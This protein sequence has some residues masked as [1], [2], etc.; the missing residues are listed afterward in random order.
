M[1][2]TGKLNLK[3]FIYRRKL[4]RS[5]HLGGSLREPC[6]SAPEPLRT[7][8]PETFP[9]R[10]R[11]T[12]GSRRRGRRKPQR[13]PRGRG[14]APPAQQRGRSAARPHV[15]AAPP[16]VTDRLYSS[17]PGPGAPH[18]AEEL[19]AALRTT[20]RLRGAA[21]KQLS[22]AALCRPRSAP[23]HRAA[24]PPTN[25]GGLELLPSHTD[26]AADLRH[27]H[28]PLRLPSTAVFRRRRSR[29]PPQR[30]PPPGCGTHQVLCVFHQALMG[31]RRP[32]PLPPP[33]GSAP[34]ACRLPL[35][36]A[37]PGGAGGGPQSSASQC[38]GGRTPTPCAGTSTTL[39]WRRCA[40]AAPSPQRA[41]IGLQP[42]WG[43][44]ALRTALW[45]KP[46]G[47]GGEL[48]SGAEVG[49]VKAA[50]TGLVLPFDEGRKT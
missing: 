42:V 4:L 12:A 1:S 32:L 37:G 24:P 5:Q 47:N 22:T 49:W 38:A 39:A 18:R 15:P 33:L 31:R 36:G 30:G 35:R 14:S 7:R 29:S 3:G 13:G 44:L 25:G 48:G 19:P 23:P 16:R 21:H 8:L 50:P 28:W 11:E 9:C 6:P 46:F 45:G 17:T 10:S 40:G 2:T 27:R 41:T 43:F 26:T 20:A 34:S